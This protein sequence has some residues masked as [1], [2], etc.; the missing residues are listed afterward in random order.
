MFLAVPEIH[1]RERRVVNKGST[2]PLHVER[3]SQCCTDPTYPSIL[4]VGPVHIAMKQQLQ[5]PV[6]KPP[7]STIN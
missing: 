1:Q 2:L 3:G 7:G 5:H 6:R 4:R